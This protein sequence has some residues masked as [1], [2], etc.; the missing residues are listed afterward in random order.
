MPSFLLSTKT[1]VIICILTL[2]TILSGCSDN[3][4]RAAAKKAQAAV[5]AAI[6]KYAATGDFDAAQKAL[7]QSLGG[8]SGGEIVSL[9]QGNLKYGKAGKMQEE[10]TLLW[11][12][13]DENVDELSGML[14]Q[15]R[16]M[17][18]EKIQLESVLRSR[19]EE[20]KQLG[21]QLDG[22]ANATGIAAKLKDAQGKLTGLKSQQSELSQ[23]F[24]EKL[25]QATELQ[26][27]ADDLLAKAELTQ[28][29]TKAQLQ[30]QAYNVLLGSKETP[31]KNTYLAE[32]QQLKDQLD[33]VESE[34]ALVEPKVATLTAQAAKIKIRIDELDKSDFPTK[35]NERITTINSTSTR[36]QEEFSGVLGQIEQT[37]TQM[38]EKMKQI[39]DL[40]VSAQKDFKKITSG[41]SLR[42]FARVAAAEAMLGEARIRSAYALSQ[43]QLAARLAIFASAETTDSQAQLKTLAQRYVDESDAIAAKAIADYNDAANLYGKIPARKDDFA[44]AV[45]KKRIFVLAQK[46][47]LAER[48]EN[49]DVKAQTIGQAKD[50]IEKAVKFDPTFE[51]SLREP[52]Y[53]ILTGAA[54]ET[55]PAE[56]IPAVIVAPT[57][58]KEANT[59]APKVEAE[60]NLPAEE[61]NLPTKEPNEAMA[62]PNQ[63]ADAQSL[64]KGKAEQLVT[65]MSQGEFVDAVFLFDDN[66]KQALPVTK[67]AETWKQLETVGGQ[68]K[69]LGQ[70]RIE[71]IQGFE[72][73]FVPAIWEK[74]KL[75]FKVVFDKQG[76]VAGLWTETPK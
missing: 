4:D 61:P 8:A 3:P 37:Q 33:A 18:T 23:K 54:A 11:A 14:G 63:S 19:Q 15:I 27:Q 50:L 74:N 71:T 67:L 55:L 20:R 17:Q 13:I 64:L 75:D 43:R 6:S 76:N 16:Q 25:K 46:A 1:S 47:Y 62:E 73:I 21:L 70:S 58:E 45:L 22:D 38:G 49:M 59:P 53:N 29:E 12:G 39:E 40:L 2:I 36:F 66:M 44:I 48:I 5:D 72:T 10:F 30:K 31:G 56:K 42:E 32:A 52:P 28:G 26:R 69:A 24:S 65:L 7:N 34:I 51:S 35:S 57:K 9:I 68:F 60:P 41:E